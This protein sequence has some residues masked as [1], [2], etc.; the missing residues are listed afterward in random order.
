M[1]KKTLVIGASTN[2]S[3]YSHIAIRLLRKHGIEVEAWGLK[4]GTIEDVIIHHKPIIFNEIYT[5]TLYVGSQNQKEY[6][7]PIKLI[8]PQ[9]IIFNPGTENP[10]LDIICR[11]LGIEVMYACTLVLLNTYQY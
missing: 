5:I 1:P 11:D 7:E 9:R 6:F 2:P 10:E 8:N 3:R 4:S